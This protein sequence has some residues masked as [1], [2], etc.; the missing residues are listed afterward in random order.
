MLIISDILRFWPLLFF[1][2]LSPYCK[3]GLELLCCVQGRSRPRCSLSAALSIPTKSGLTSFTDAGVL[4]GRRTPGICAEMELAHLRNPPGG[5]LRKRLAD[6]TTG[7][8]TGCLESWLQVWAVQLDCLSEFKSHLCHLLA[9]QPWGSHLTPLC[10]SF[11]F[12][13]VRMLMALYS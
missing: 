10:L 13:N 9:G 11:F 7:P 8:L 4:P 6:F 1:L 3:L 12:C 5:A 2:E